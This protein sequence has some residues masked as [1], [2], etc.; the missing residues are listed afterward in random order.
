MNTVTLTNGNLVVEPQGLDRIWS[1]RRSLEF[2]VA[3]LRGATLDPGANAEPKGIRA[4]GLQLPGK[5]CG[6]FHRDGEKS[7]WNVSGPD[8]TVVIELA[9]E[10]FDRLYLTVDEPRD[11]VDRINAAIAER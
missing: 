11:L 5:W 4:P 10:D 9:D 2:P 6:T 8:R 7:F 1:L 3:H